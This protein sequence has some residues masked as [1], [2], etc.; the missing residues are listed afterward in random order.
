MS[1]L[2]SFLPYVPL[3]VFV[4]FPLWGWLFRLQLVR[5]KDMDDAL[6]KEREAWEKVTEALAKADADLSGKVHV[7]HTDNQVM[8]AHLQALPTRDDLTPVTQGLARL[9]GLLEGRLQTIDRV[10]DA[11]AR[12]DD[13]IAEAA[14]AARHVPGGE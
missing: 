13:I 10:Q 14:R 9:T 7:L 5:Q 8:R 3:L 12:H 1:G 11:V 4:V 6:K 2:Q